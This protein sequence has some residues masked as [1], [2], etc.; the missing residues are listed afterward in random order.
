[1]NDQQ[2]RDRNI[3]VFRAMLKA[4]GEKDFATGCDFL[5]EDVRCDWPYLPIP[6]MSPVMVGRETIRSFFSAG[7][8]P[9]AGLNYSIEQIYALLD[10]DTLIADY[11]SHS[12]HLASGLAYNNNYLGIM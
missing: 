1:M 2:R 6:D 3:A 9:F 4:C 7:Q 5:T 11:S 10:A 12:R 8:Q